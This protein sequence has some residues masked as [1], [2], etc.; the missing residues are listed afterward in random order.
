MKVSVVIP[1]HGRPD[2]VEK[3]LASMLETA[4]HLH[5]LEIILVENGVRAGAEQAVARFRKALPIQYEFLETANV[6]AARNH[7]ASLANGVLVIFIDDDVKLAPGFIAA[8]RAAFVQHGDNCFYGGSLVADYEQVPPDWLEPFLPDSA[9]GFDPEI[10]DPQRVGA[11]LFLGGN[12]ARSRALLGRAGGFDLM[13][14]SGG[15]NTGFIGE[16][17]RLQQRMLTSGAHGVYVRDARVLHWVPASRC[18]LDWLLARRQ[19]TGITEA[20]TAPVPSRAVL[21]CPTWM[22]RAWFRDSMDIMSARLTGRP[23]NNVVSQRLHQA[24]LGAFIGQAVRQHFGR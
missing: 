10:D 2:L 13:S 20:K 24:Y 4:Q 11:P 23:M 3:C 7:G 8:Y 15:T 9:R 12:M 22:F 19:R 1:A 16:E 17:T 5:D 21:G 18:S 14:A 6:G